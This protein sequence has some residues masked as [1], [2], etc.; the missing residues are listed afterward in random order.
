MV[1]SFFDAACDDICPILETELLQAYADLGP[2]APRVAVVTVNTDPL[3]LSVSSARPPEA[4]RRAHW[5]ATWY[6]LTGLCP[7]SI[8]CGAHTGSPSMSSATPASCHI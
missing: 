4:A 7:G 3:D 2:L 6:F 1:L 5:P 8:Q